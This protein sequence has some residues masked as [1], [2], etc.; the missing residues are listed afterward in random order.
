MEIRGIKVIY[1][2]VCVVL[3]SA[4][5]LS[6]WASNAFRTSNGITELWILGPS[7]T[8]SGYPSNVEAE[9]SYKIYLGL[10]NH[11]G[12]YRYY[13]IYLKLR[14]QTESLPN[15]DNHSPSQ[16]DPLYSYY[17]FLQNDGAWEREIV[18]SFQGVSID[19][20]TARI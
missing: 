13:L 8:V 11:E 7:H 18:F 5:I 16:L 2:T 19:G 12:D 3:F 20:T 1:V 14:N 17:S 9:K 6:A 15:S 4:L 10:A